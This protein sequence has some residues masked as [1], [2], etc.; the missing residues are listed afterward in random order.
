MGCVNHH[1]F[2]VGIAGEVFEHGLP[3]TAFGP[4]VEARAARQVL[5]CEQ[6]TF[7]NAVPAAKARQV[8]V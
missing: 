5:F 2:H 6:E 3:D 4:T 1:G 7:V 8:L